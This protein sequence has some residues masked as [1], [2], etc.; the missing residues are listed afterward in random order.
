MLR[1]VVPLCLR[2]QLLKEVHNGKFAGHFA[3]RKIYKTLRKK[4][5]WN[6]MHTDVQKYCRACLECATRKSP[7][8]GT[9]PPLN[10]IPIG[11]PFH[12]IG[13]DVLQLPLSTVISML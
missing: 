2:E 10:P 8:H 7:G 3:E 12:R 4:Y 13:I 9:R 11:G 6:G 1:C 5:W